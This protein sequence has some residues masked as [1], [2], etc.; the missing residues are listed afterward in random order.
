MWF[1]FNLYLKKKPVDVLNQTK[2]MRGTALN[3]SYLFY[4]IKGWLVVSL[5]CVQSNLYPHLTNKH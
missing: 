1:F 4:S 3:K 5:Y 2:P